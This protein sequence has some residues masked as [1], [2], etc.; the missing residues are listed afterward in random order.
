MTTE[1]L[2]VPATWTVDEALQLIRRVGGAKET[3]YAMYVLDP[4]SGALRHVVS[5]RELI[6]SDRGRRVDQVGSTRKMLTVTPRTDREDVARLI[7][8]Y[9]LLAVPVVD[10]DG[11]VLGIVTVDDVIDALVAETTED[12]QKFGGMEALDEPYMRDRPAPDAAQARAAGS[13]RSSSARC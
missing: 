4:N 1:F 5:L 6:L 13:P 9:D 12:V 11:R 8:K 10:A 7:S 3:V 2:T